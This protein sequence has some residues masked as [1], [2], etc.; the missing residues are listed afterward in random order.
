VWVILFTYRNNTNKEE[1]QMQPTLEQVIEQLRHDF[2][3]NA[4]EVKELLQRPLILPFTVTAACPY[5]FDAKTL[6]AALEYI[7]DRRGYSK[8]YNGGSPFAWNVKAHNVDLADKQNSPLDGAWQKYIE[9]PRGQWVH[10]RAFDMAQFYYHEEWS[11]YPGNDQG[12]WAYNFMGTS[13]GWLCL[14]KWRGI[15]IGNMDAESLAEMLSG[16][17]YAAATK[18]DEGFARFY[19]GIVCA[20]EDFTPKSADENV[21]EQYSLLREQWEEQGKG[22]LPEIAEGMIQAGKQIAADYGVEFNL[23]DALNEMATS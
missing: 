22:I 13:G 14:S 11:A 10:S 1:S 9:S 19:V 3:L 2:F 5:L 12:D 6:G 17:V 16:I 7:I 4:R 15:S 8:R 21:S 23:Q 18:G 20:D